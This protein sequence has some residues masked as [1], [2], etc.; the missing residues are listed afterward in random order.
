MAQSYELNVKSIKGVDAKYG[1]ARLCVA[2]HVDGKWVHNTHPKEASVA[3]WNDTTTLWADSSSS[4]IGLRV[5]DR[6]NWRHYVPLMNE[7]CLAK[8][9]IGIHILLEAQKD[10]DVPLKYVKSKEM[11]GPTLVLRVSTIG[12]IQVGELEIANAKADVAP[13]ESG[14]VG[15]SAI[16]VAGAVQSSDF[17]S[18]LG[19]LLE[20]V[21]K[22]GDEFVKIHPITQVAWT[23]LHAIYKAV[24]NQQE[25]G[26][27]I[28]QLVQTMAEVYAFAKDVDS[29]SAA[30]KHL[31][32]TVTTIVQQTAKCAMFVREYTGH[33]FLGRLATDLMS[34]HTKTIQDFV[35]IFVELQQSLNRGLCKYTVFA[36]AH[37]E[38][39]TMHI[40]S[41]IM[42][43]ESMTMHTKSMTR[44]IQ[45]TVENSDQSAKLQTLRP[46][47][48]DASLR[49]PCLAGTRCD[50]LSFITTW[51]TTPPDSADSGNIL[52]L[53]GVSG[54]GKSTIATSISQHLRALNS[55][56]TFLF[57]TRG[58][59]TTSSPS[60]VIPTIAFG[61]AQLN[62]HLASAICAA[63]A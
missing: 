50:L 10:V 62:T 6:H 5:H 35:T 57:F 28:V 26:G 20:S 47:I 58:S 34:D 48:M 40:E 17:M 2:I 51:L 55:L 8:A 24:K 41:M 25:T 13:L 4:I 19:T 18:V 39:T 52:W 54:V 30:K 37:I 36:A 29:L 56:G 7:K 53:Y 14:P 63:L 16:Q 45:K 27:K 32:D 21:L 42:H 31:E 44:Q 33:G 43:I 61:L 23:A 3:M 22:I 49:L 1:K 12:N 38:S 60:S 11:S 46:A 15:F 59:L 9:E